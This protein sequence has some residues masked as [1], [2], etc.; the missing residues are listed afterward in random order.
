MKKL[1]PRGGQGSVQIDVLKMD[2]SIYSKAVY[3]LLSSYK[4]EKQMA[5]PSVRTMS[6]DLKISKSTVLR[7]IKELEENNLLLVKRGKSK[8]GDNLVNVYIPD[9]L[10]Q[11]I[12][13]ENY[14]DVWEESEGGGGPPQT[15]GVVSPVEHNIIINNNKKE[16]KKIYRF[17][18]HLKLS[19]EEFEKLKE[20]GFSKEEI[21]LILDDIENYRKNTNYKSLYLTARKW[22]NSLKAEKEKNISARAGQSVLDFMIP[23]N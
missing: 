19:F 9:V 21:D 16:T 17:F 2:M 12:D 23:G 14:D 20:Q 15:P 13:T 3:C 7:A 10:Y 1:I 8:K 5:F 6:S 18:G 11:E 22:L 4:G